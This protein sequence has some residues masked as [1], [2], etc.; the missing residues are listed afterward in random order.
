MGKE[1]FTLV[2]KMKK[3]RKGRERGR[4]DYEGKKER[5]SDAGEERKEETTEMRE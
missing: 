3:Q 4:L 1:E 2:G 5:G